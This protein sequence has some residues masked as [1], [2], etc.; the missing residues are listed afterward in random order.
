MKVH[1]AGQICSSYL[2]IQHPG[3]RWEGGILSSRS[4][5]LSETLS[6]NSKNRNNNNMGP[7]IQTDELFSF[8]PPYLQMSSFLLI[9]EQYSIV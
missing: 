6:Q 1:K 8:K 7:S 3:L 4:S 5:T 9:A 2:R